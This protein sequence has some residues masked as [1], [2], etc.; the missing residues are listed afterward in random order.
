MATS[1]ILESAGSEGRKAPTGKNT[2]GDRGESVYEIAWKKNIP[3]VERKGSFR[4]SDAAYPAGKSFRECYLSG[5]WLRRK[6]SG[7]RSG[8]SP[9]QTRTRCRP[10]ACRR[11]E[12]L[13]KVAGGGGGANDT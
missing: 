6:T 5:K 4:R 3:G 8:M 13:G 9:E 11:G 7:H 12:P 10:G 1:G 2:G